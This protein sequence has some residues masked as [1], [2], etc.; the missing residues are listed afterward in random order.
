M[1]LR[2]LVLLLPVTW[3]LASC[4][5]FGVQD[6]YQEPQFSHESTRLTGLTWS[7]LT[8]RSTVTLTNPNAFRLPVSGFDA[9]LWLG[10]EPW[11]DL[12]TPELSGIAARG[13]TTLTFDWDLVSEGLLRRA[14]AAYDAGQAELELRLN[15]TLEVPVLGPRQLDWSHSFT[16][17][18]PK[19]PTVRLADWAVEDVSL[20]SLTVRLDLLVDNPN[21]FGLSAGPTQLG[22]EGAGGRLAGLTLDAMSLDGG[23]KRVASTR[24]TLSFGDLGLSL[25]EAM[26]TGRWPQ[27]LSLNWQSPV[28]S[29]DLK[30]ALPDIS[31]QLTP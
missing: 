7:G 26:R 6:V 28:S 11:I 8:G 10:D 12:Q 21:R 24:A 15:P 22:I 17:P 23:E 27:D 13:S 14:Q 25:A 16:V 30:L 1:S 29:P 4:A 5:N 2:R 31:G 9:A 20:T 19:L 18:V 3:L